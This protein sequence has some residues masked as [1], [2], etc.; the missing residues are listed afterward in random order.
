[1][2][3]ATIVALSHCSVF[4]LSVLVKIIVKHNF[5][6]KRD[7]K[8]GTKM[9]PQENDGIRIIWLICASML[10]Y[11]V[12][13]SPTEFSS[14]K[15]LE[16]GLTETYDVGFRLHLVALKCGVV[17]QCNLEQHAIAGANIHILR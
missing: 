10:F 4:R 13:V 14:A 12:V 15:E 8:D 17:H 11:F 2:P 6:D 7:E 5:S 3:E 9:R 1:M 16:V